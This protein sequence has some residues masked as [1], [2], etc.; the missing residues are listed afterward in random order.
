MNVMNIFRLPDLGEGLQEA[1]IVTWHVSVGDHVVADQ[2]LVSVET[3][4]AVMEIPAP[5]SGLIASLQG[6]P[7]ER[8]QIGATLVEFDLAAAADSGTV[9]GRIPELPARPAPDTKAPA[10]A[11]VSGPRAVPAVRVLAERLG[12]DL[13]AVTP[14]GPDGSISKS[15]V[16]NAAAAG[17]DG[18][19]VEPL[20]GPRRAMAQ[21]MARAHAEVVPATITELADIEDW[22][23][24]SGVTWRLIRA[25]VRACAAEPALNAAYLGLDRGRQLHKEVHLGIA[26]DT[27][28]GLFV[29]VLRDADRRSEGDLR[30][31]LDVLKAQVKDRSIAPA[32]LQGATITL[33]NFGAVGGIFATPAV[34]PPQCAIL[35]AGRVHERVLPIDG[36]PR[37]GRALP[38]S[39]T[40]DHRVVTGGEGARFLAA[41]LA[42]L[43]QAG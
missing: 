3:D 18:A 27:R 11:S 20:R 43:E 35:A 6:E 37:V 42:D 24:G 34:V 19:G 8:V 26:V 33:S 5:Q 4:K 1:E 25:M 7:G 16:E 28:A 29:P 21:T 39:L 40:F 23:A 22:P 15:D 12:L 9:V 14:T 2:P 31:E 10:N 32:A 30:T 41:V 38:L 13:G 17:Q 36:K